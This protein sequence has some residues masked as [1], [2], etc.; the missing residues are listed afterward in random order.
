MDLSLQVLSNLHLEL[1]DIINFENIITP[2][3]DML[4]LLGD[5]GCPTQTSLGYFL[6]WCSLNYE[7]V[8]YVPGNTEY[9]SLTGEFDMNVINE[10]LSKICEKFQNVY[11]LNND[12][13][14]VDDKY[15]FI[16]STLWS[17][18]PVQEIADLSDFKYIYKS[19]NQLIT[20]DDICE[21]YR[22]NKKWVEH[23]IALANNDALVPIVLTHHQSF[24]KQYTYRRSSNVIQPS[25]IKLWCTA[26][27]PNTHSY[28]DGYLLYSNR[29]INMLSMQ[30]E[31]NF[32][33][34]H[35]LHLN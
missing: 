27:A 6:Q 28:H 21:L 22:N 30:Q 12:T 31:D 26:N 20:H 3:A 32:K 17:D 34:N 25:M 18:T 16:G 2:C 9:Y 14:L 33:H 8:I 24:V 13:L 15:M 23:Q 19:P 35:K 1:N 10:S 11:Y 5:I 7:Y 4:V 29:Y